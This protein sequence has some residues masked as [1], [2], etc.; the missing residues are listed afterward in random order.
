MR[1][2]WETAWTVLQAHMRLQSLCVHEYACICTCIYIWNMCFNAAL[3]D[4]CTWFLVNIVSSEAGRHKQHIQYFINLSRLQT[5]ARLLYS[6]WLHAFTRSHMAV[7]RNSWC[8]WP[9]TASADAYSGCFYLHLQHLIAAHFVL[10]I[11]ALREREGNRI[12]PKT[13]TV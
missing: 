2:I 8:S 7:A 1:E 13:K 4:L 6:W 9:M 5:D 3:Y 10:V 11:P 12:K